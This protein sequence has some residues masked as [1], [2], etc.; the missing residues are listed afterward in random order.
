MSITKV[1]PSSTLVAMA[2]GM[3]FVAVQGCGGSGHAVATKAPLT[4][5]TNT[6]ARP[7]TE[8]TSTALD[9]DG[10]HDGVAGRRYDSDDSGVVGFGS[11]AGPQD[12]AAITALLKRYYAIAA[13]G[14]GAVGCSLMYSVFAEAIVED[15]GTPLGPRALKGKTCAAVMSRLFE[16]EHKQLVEKAKTLR[17]ASVRVSGRRGIAFLMFTGSTNRYISVQRERNN[18]KLDALLDVK[19]T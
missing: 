14:D 8:A 12:S 6:I 15:Y 9:A 4:G 5:P 2:V 10:D 19:F 1:A 17:V 7:S 11:V 18:W 16:Q 13:K 3:A